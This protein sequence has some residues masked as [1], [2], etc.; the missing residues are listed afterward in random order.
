MRARAPN[1]HTQKELTQMG[2]VGGS[3]EKA[4]IAGRLF[5]AATDADAGVK[6][7][8][9]ENEVQSNGDGS[10]RVVKTRVPWSLDGVT[11]SIDNSKGDLQFLQ[12]VQDKK[13]EVPMSLTLA[14]GSV[15]HGKGQIV[16]ELK[17][18]TMASTAAV[19]LMGSKRLAKQ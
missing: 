1:D 18:Q 14:D 17:M 4:S 3:L 7:G 10:V 11:L 16:G 6:L 2:A 13:E 12:D 15:Y 9:Y 19:A 5:A 8:G